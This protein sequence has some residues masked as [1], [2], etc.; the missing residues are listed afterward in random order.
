MANALYLQEPVT[1]DLFP[2][3]VEKEGAATVSSHLSSSQA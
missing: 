2:V 3:R 1:G